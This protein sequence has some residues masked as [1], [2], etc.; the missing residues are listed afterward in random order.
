MIQY[1]AIFQYIG[2]IPRLFLE[3]TGWICNRLHISVVLYPMILIMPNTWWMFSIWSDM[4]L[5]DRHIFIYFCLF[6]YI[7]VCLRRV[8]S[9]RYSIDCK[10]CFVKHHIKCVNI[11]R[12]D[13][14]DNFWVCPYCVQVIFPF[15]HINNDKDF[16]STIIIP[17]H[18][19]QY[20][21]KIVWFIYFL[22]WWYN[23]ICHW[24]HQDTYI[25]DSNIQLS[26]LKLKE[27]N[28]R[29]VMQKST[30]IWY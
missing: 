18:F 9:F 4:T 11:N 20:T 26:K 13:V 21:V 17:G 28:Y 25:Q 12:D 15:N 2:H 7:I 5:S 24:C 19:N 1:C 27:N 29:N 30:L 22:R 3:W 6:T 23:C 16:Y 8:Q 10:T 14:I